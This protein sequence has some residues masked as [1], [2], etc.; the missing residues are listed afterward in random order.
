MNLMMRI[1]GGVLLIYGDA[2]LLHNMDPLGAADP[3][4]AITAAAAAFAAGV[5]LLI[6]RHGRK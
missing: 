6:L 2:A 3:V 1:T 4:R 5:L